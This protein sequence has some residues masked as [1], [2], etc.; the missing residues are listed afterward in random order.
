M[1]SLTSLATCAVLVGAGVLG[2]T[3]SADATST[4]AAH[5]PVKPS[6]YVAL[7]DSY[8]SGAGIMPQVVGAP[9]TCSRSQLNY[10]HRIAEVTHPRVFRDVTCSGAKTSDFFSSQAAGVPPQLRAVTKRTRLVTM[11]IGGNDESVF[12]SSFFGCAQLTPTNPTGNPCQTRYG[13]TFVDLIRTKTYPHLV[14]ALRAVRHR[15]PHATVVIL[16]Y[17]QILPPTGS[18]ACTAVT[19][20]AVGDVPW[21]V[22]QEKTLNRVVRRAA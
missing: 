12:T 17:P 4:A 15:A 13:S 7:G 10:A 8:S 6:P 9:A 16:G 20:I 22:A 21:L 2:A 18:P 3:S 11:S 5:R 1:R 14:H 19:G